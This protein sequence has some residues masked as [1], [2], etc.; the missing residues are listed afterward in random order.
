[1]IRVEMS[2]PNS[3][4]Y[5]DA[6]DLAKNSGYGYSVLDEG[7]FDDSNFADM[8]KHYIKEDTPVVEPAP[9]LQQPVPEAKQ[10]DHVGDLK[11]M[12][13]IDFST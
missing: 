11:E 8:E 5:K 6:Y 12:F 10:V 9:L 2:G 1:M 4:I 7:F 13:P 3:A